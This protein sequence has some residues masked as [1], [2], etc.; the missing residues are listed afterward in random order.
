MGLDILPMYPFVICHIVQQLFSVLFQRS[1]SLSLPLSTFFIWYVKQEQQNT[2]NIHDSHPNHCQHSQNLYTYIKAELR[3]GQMIANIIKWYKSNQHTG[4]NL[5]FA[6]SVE[7]FFLDGTIDISIHGLNNFL[8][9]LLLENVKFSIIWVF[10]LW[11]IWWAKLHSR[12]Y[13]QNQCTCSRHSILK[14]S[15]YDSWISD[16]PY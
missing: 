12:F 2:K 7:T 3:Q 15:T 10:F 4:L 13:R 6:G 9:V 16:V 11:I 1:L 5:D 14:C 8:F